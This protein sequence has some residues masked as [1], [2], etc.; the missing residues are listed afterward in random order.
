M[1]ALLGDN[2]IANTLGSPSGDDILELPQKFQIAFAKPRVNLKMN[3]VL[4]VNKVDHLL[5][6]TSPPL[7][8]ICQVKKCLVN[9]NSSKA[10]GVNKIS[11]LVA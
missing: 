6:N 4:N 5:K 9:L 8:S 7:P 2:N 3:S 11:S 10:I 1:Y